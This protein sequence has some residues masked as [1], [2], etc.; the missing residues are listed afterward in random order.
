[1]MNKSLRASIRESSHKRIYGFHVVRYLKLSRRK[2]AAAGAQ[3]SERKK[4]RRFRRL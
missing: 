3:G 2:A 1:M 4:S